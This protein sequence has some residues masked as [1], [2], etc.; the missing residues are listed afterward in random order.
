MVGEEAEQRAADDAPGEQAA[1][2]EE[3]A[4]NQRCGLTAIGHRPKLS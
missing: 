3:V 1:E 2:A 4:T